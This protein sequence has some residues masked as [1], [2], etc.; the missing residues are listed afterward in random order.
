MRTF[1]KNVFAHRPGRKHLECLGYR[2]YRGVFFLQLLQIPLS[3]FY[4]LS[5]KW[6]AKN[7]RFANIRLFYIDLESNN[8]NSHHYIFIISHFPLAAKTWIAKTS[9]F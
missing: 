8:K 1:H 7:L 3:D 9:D 2:E 4:L 6:I 5:N